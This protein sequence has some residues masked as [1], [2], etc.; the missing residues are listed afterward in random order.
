MG[1]YLHYQAMPDGGRLAR[2]LRT[3][4]P[5]RAMYCELVH[6]P[7]GPW[8]TDRLPPDDLDELLTEVAGEPAFGSLPV[9]V[10]VYNDLRAELE[11]SEREYPGLR[12]R[13][14]YF[15]LIEFDV[16][17]AHGLVTAGC[18]NAEWLA[19]ALVW[20][21][22]RF[23]LD[24]FRSRNVALRYVPPPMVSV[25]AEQ[26]QGV[27]AGAFDGWT[28]DWEAFRAVYAEAAA[29]GEGVVVA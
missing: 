18:P 7:A 11:R 14:A 9:A 25:A 26:L 12:R 28:G 10:Q 8:D 24:G 6:H 2:L 29:R 4:R 1:V 20:G 3:E 27:G 13:A 16:Q 19:E 23:A 22:E 15:K 5:L 21:V 17:L